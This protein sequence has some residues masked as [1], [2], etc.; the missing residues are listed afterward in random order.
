MSFVSPAVASTTSLDWVSASPALV[1]EILSNEHTSTFAKSKESKSIALPICVL[2][3][4]NFSTYCADPAVRLFKAFNSAWKLILGTSGN[5]GN[6]PVILFASGVKLVFQIN[7]LKKLKKK[8]YLC[9]SDVKTVNKSEHAGSAL[10]GLLVIPY[11]SNIS[12]VGP[13]SDWSDSSARWA[14]HP[15]KEIKN[16]CVN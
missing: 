6:I 5:G 14:V 7:D 10:S 8:K 13:Y 4:A 9:P 11:Y 2:C 15:K 12:V 1:K 3:V 16:P